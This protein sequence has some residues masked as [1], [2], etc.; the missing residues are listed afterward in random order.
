MN[1]DSYRYGRRVTLVGIAVNTLITIIKFTLGILGNSAVLFA[2]GFDS[3][4]DIGATTGVLIGYKYAASPKDKEHPHGHG[5]I[6]SISALFIGLSLGLTGNYIIYKNSLRI[7]R[8]EYVQPEWIALAGVAIVIALKISLYFY[9]V[10]AGRKL[11]SPSISAS[12]ADH[13]AD[14]YRLSG[15]FVGV[16][17]AILNYPIID[18]VAALLVAII[19]IRTSFSITRGAFLDLIDTQMPQEILIKL[20][21][22]IQS[23][24]AESH[25]VEAVGRR[26]GPRYQ[27]M[28][29]VCVSPYIRAVDNV[30]D[31][32][33]LETLIL[34]TI[35]EIQGVDI[36]IDVDKEQADSFE[37]RFKKHVYNVLEKYKGH[38]V[39][40]ENMEF[41]FMEEQHEAHFDMLVS[42]DM[43]VETAHEITT[44]IEQA[45]YTEFPDAQIII[46]I[47]PAKR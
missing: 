43:P 22:T 32:S 46:H 19:I 18:P 39:R 14:V 29:K 6:E 37:E 38:Y 21:K 20:K 13:I 23:W 25:L 11:N 1:P 5:K 7:Y 36:E 9:T 2:E 27:V 12:A 10:K 24:D 4:A 33:Q 17:F 3:L 45:I 30:E 35:P 16:L 28:V 26:M 47:E 41:H 8:H 31:L 40:L 34:K 15:V 44:K 42:P